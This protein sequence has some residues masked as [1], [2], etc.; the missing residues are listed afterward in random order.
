LNTKS[1]FSERERLDELQQLVSQVSAALVEGQDVILQS[2]RQPQAIS[3]AQELGN[4]NGYSAAGIGR[5]IST[6][7]AEIT[8]GTLELTGQNRLIV[9]GGETSSAV[10]KRLGIFGQRIWKEIQP[11]LPSCIS[12]TG[13][14]LLLVLKSGSFGSPDFF[15]QALTHLRNQ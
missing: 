13:K 12:L 1:L 15:E 2:P 14:P 11:G 8:A 9:A 7:L 5:L 6:A 3:E 4:E 10:C